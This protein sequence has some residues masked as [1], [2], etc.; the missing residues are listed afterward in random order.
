MEENP[1]PADQVR[2]ITGTA[3]DPVVVEKIRS[4]W[5]E[6]LRNIQPVALGALLRDADVGGTDNQGHLVLTFQH[7]FHCKKVSE[8]TNLQRIED[9]LVEV[10]HQPIAIRCLPKDEWK[11][12]VSSQPQAGRQPRADRQSPASRAPRAKQPDIPLEEDELIRRAQEELGA[13]ARIND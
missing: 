5:P 11:A 10:F 2:G 3:L 6:L 12:Q 13:V 9:V 8:A 4:R 7:A 1:A